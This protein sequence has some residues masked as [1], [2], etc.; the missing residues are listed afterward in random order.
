V[1]PVAM[2][3]TSMSSVRLKLFSTPGNVITG[4]W[5]TEKLQNSRS[6]L[7]GLSSSVAVGYFSATASSVMASF[8]CS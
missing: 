5:M 1:P 4:R 6:T 7:F 3:T 8:A 2:R